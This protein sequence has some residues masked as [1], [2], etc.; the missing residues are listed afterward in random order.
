MY[1]GRAAPARG[2]QDGHNRQ[3]ACGRSL[4]SGDYTPPTGWGQPT[5]TSAP[6][7][8]ASK[9]TTD[10]FWPGVCSLVRYVGFGTPT[11]AALAQDRQGVDF[12][13]PDGSRWSWRNRREVYKSFKDCTFRRSRP[14]GSATEWDK[15]RAGACDRLLFTWTSGGCIVDWLLLD[16]A[17]VTP[18]LD[19]SWPEKKMCDATFVTIPWRDLKAVGAIRTASRFIMGE[20]RD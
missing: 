19:R 20:L 17:P 11:A 14:N 12:T 7:W 5:E 1:K 2:R 4:S 6:T 18:L 15:L 9:A 13:T 8:R 10:R 16:A 3:E